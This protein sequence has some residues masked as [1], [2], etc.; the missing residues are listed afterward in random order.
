MDKPNNY[1]QQTIQTLVE[2]YTKRAAEIN[3]SRSQL[4]EDETV[5]FI[6][7]ESLADPTRLEG[8]TLSQD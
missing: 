7:S 2:K 6:L 8:V 5:I 3:A 1:N 4:I